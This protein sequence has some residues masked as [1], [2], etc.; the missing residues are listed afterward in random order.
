MGG[1]MSMIKFFVLPLILDGSYDESVV[2]TV[3]SSWSIL[4]DIVVINGW[5]VA[6]SVMSCSMGISMQVKIIVSVMFI[7]MRVFMCVMIHWLHLKHKV[8]S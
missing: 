6:L 2:N 3:M 5:M 4:V 7:W 1:V 8:T